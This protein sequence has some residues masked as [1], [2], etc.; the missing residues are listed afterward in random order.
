MYCI[1][2]KLKVPNHSFRPNHFVVLVDK[3]PV[4]AAAVFVDDDDDVKDADA[5]VI[6]FYDDAANVND[7]VCSAD[8]DGDFDDEDNDDAGPNSFALWEIS[9]HRLLVRSPQKK[10]TMFTSSLNSS[11]SLQRREQVENSIFS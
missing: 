6:V 4:V 5:G 7:I 10:K 11:F 8:D 9:R 2:F 1:C 3:K